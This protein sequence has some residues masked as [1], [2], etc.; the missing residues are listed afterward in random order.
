MNTGRDDQVE[1]ALNAAHRIRARR[2]ATAGALEFEGFVNLSQAMRNDG[3]EA[4]PSES[5]GRILG[6]FGE[7]APG[8][9]SCRKL[10]AI[11]RSA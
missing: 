4:H 3:R 7:F 5:V 2:S 1:S 6:K 8:N 11:E 10:F 9:E